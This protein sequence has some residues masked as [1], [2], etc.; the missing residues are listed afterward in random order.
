MDTDKIKTRAKLWLFIAWLLAIAIMAMGFAKVELGTFLCAIAM[1]AGTIAAHR[2]LCK[3]LDA[4][5]G[6]Q[7]DLKKAQSDL[8]A[9]NKKLD[10]AKAKS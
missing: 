8:A 7:D 3:T 2:W 5:D 1:V 9:A 6:I 10:K 4:V